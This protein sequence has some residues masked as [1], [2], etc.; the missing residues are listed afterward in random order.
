MNAP[1]SNKDI[2]LLLAERAAGTSFDQIQTHHFPTRSLGAVQS[3]FYRYKEKDMSTYQSGA[4]QSKTSAP[5]RG[6][7]DTSQT[8]LLSTYSPLT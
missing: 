2:S 1:W 5:S 4:S 6:K 7:F 3:T 8:H